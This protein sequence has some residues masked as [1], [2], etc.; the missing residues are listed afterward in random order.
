M[1]KNCRERGLNTLVINK[2]ESQII[3]HPDG[4]LVLGQ[5]LKILNTMHLAPM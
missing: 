1:I 4:P 5:Y 3:G 2:V